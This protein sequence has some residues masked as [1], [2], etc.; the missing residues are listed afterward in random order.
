MYLYDSFLLFIV[1]FLAACLGTDT[2]VFAEGLTVASISG[3]ALLPIV[4]IMVAI[5]EEIMTTD[6]IDKITKGNLTFILFKL[7]VLKN[8]RVMDVKK[9]V[10]K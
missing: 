8:M 10:D 4:Y 9:W 1:G 5:E 7:K 3:V 2:E 6:M